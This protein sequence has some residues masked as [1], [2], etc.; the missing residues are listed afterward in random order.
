MRWLLESPKDEGWLPG[1]TNHVIR[2]LE[3]F[4]PTIEDDQNT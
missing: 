1:E 2:G 4:S 3:N